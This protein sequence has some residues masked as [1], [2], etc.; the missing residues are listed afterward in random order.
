M[1]TEDIVPYTFVLSTYAQYSCE[2]HPRCCEQRY[3]IHSHSGE[4]RHWNNTQQFSY[5]FSCSHVSQQFSRFGIFL[6]TE[7]VWLQFLFMSFGKHVYDP[8]GYK[9][10]N[11]KAGSILI[12]IVRPFLKVIENSYQSK[13]SVYFTSSP[14]FFIIY[15]WFRKIFLF[16]C[17]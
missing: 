2:M 9:Q 5:P 8:T 12:S 4:F 17:L 3:F 10:R 15:R 1:A 16:I 14:V 6:G 13:S 7:T 11:L